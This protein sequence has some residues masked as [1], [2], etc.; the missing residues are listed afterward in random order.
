ML[1]SCRPIALSFKAA[2]KCCGD[3]RYLGMTAP[4][5]VGKLSQS[6]LVQIHCCTH[7]SL[8]LQLN[9]ICIMLESLLQLCLSLL[10]ADFFLGP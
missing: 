1:E 8:L 5:P 7:I 10:N 4:K 2:A 6:W 3:K 9:S